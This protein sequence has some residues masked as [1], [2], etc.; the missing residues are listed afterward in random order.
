MQPPKSATADPRS[1]TL[2]FKKHKTTVLLSL[3]PQTPITTA[4]D[5][6]LEALK[7]RNVTE[8]NGQFVPSESASIEFGVLVDR[9]DVEKGWTLLSLQHG[10]AT[11][12][13]NGKKE[14]NETLFHA[15]LDNG[16]IVAFRFR[17]PSGDSQTD[18]VETDVDSKDPGWDVVMPKFDDDD[19]DEE[20]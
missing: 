4:K 11:K 18:E 7:S 15:K 2:L 17:S 8:I 16:H 3:P 20:Q 6:L 10:S 1:I 9:S 12:S 5:E 14:S 13:S 19:E